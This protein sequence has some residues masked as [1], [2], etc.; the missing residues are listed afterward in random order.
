MNDVLVSKSWR[1]AIFYAYSLKD[2]FD[3][4]S[5]SLIRT[6]EDL[7]QADYFL[8]RDI[9]SFSTESIRK[10]LVNVSQKLAE[11]DLKAELISFLQ[12]SF[13]EKEQLNN[14][15]FEWIKNDKRICSFCYYFLIKNSRHGPKEEG[16]D[17]KS[18]RNAL[19]Q[20]PGRS[21]L[22]SLLDR[23]NSIRLFKIH[24]RAVV[25]NSHKDRFKIIK[26]AF[27][28]SE[29][30]LDEQQYIMSILSEAWVKSLHE[31]TNIK[32]SKWLNGK[33]HQKVTWFC[34]YIKKQESM[35]YLPW[36]PINDEELYLALQAEFDYSFLSVPKENKYLFTQAR[37][38]WNQ[39]TARNKKNGSKS[40]GIS[41]S[42]RTSKRLDWLAA[43]KDEKINVV[44]KKL[45]DKE[46]ESLDGPEK[47]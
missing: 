5:S 16:V 6:A 45:I 2:M 39:V 25:V 37:L 44:I 21:V 31:V 35:F 7:K 11:N 15:A 13:N 10:S 1:E 43:H 29:I 23:Q 9:S 34:D 46:F 18:N 27:L 19:E 33:N 28:N 17:L 36:E 47:F 3:V 4:D 22:N 32:F 20:R 8:L 40:R 12:K 38:A 41:M 42:G 14:D 24:D 26:F 30:A